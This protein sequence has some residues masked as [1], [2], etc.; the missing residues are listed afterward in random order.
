MSSPP[1]VTALRHALNALMQTLGGPLQFFWGG[2][3]ALGRGDA[4]AAPGT[5]PGERAL[6]RGVDIC[7]STGK[8]QPCSHVASDM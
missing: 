8:P 3:E 7:S 5:G 4:E 6:Q 2:N 1:L